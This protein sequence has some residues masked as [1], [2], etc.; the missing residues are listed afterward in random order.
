[1]NAGS[2][3]QDIRGAT[4]TTTKRWK[5]EDNMSDLSSKPQIINCKQLSKQFDG[6]HA[7]MPRCH[8]KKQGMWEGRGDE[9]KLVDASAWLAVYWHL[10]RNPTNDPLGFGDAKNETVIPEQ[11]LQIHTKRRICRETLGISLRIWRK[12]QHVKPPCQHS[13][14]SCRVRPRK[15]QAIHKRPEKFQFFAKAETAFGSSLNDQKSWNPQE[16][17]INWY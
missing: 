15:P 1:M 10:S 9:K 4:E 8:V 12:Q 13:L 7:R 16:E 3:L 17:D 6:S 5:D 11:N 14:N 2:K